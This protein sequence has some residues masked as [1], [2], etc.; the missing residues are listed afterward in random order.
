MKGISE[1]AAKAS[2]RRRYLFRSWVR[3]KPSAI[4]KAK[5]GKAMRPMWV[6]QAWSEATDA[7]RW[8]QSIR[9]MARSFS[10]RALRPP[11]A[12]LERVLVGSAVFMT[13]SP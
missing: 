6:S 8:S 9:A 7:Q 11:G 1:T 10:P 5:M 12:A 13:C 4:W 3:A 2:I